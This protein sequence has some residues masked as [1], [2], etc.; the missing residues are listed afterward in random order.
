MDGDRIILKALGVIGR[1]EVRYNGLIHLRGER[2]GLE[3]RYDADRKKWYAYI[4]FESSEKAF[5][6]KWRAISWK[7]RG[8]LVAGIN[9]G[10]NNLMAIYAENSLTRL[11]N[12]RPLKA[13]SHYWNMRITEYQ[14][15]LN[16]YCLKTSKRLR[17][18]Y[19]KWR[20]QVKSYIDAK[21]RQTIEWLYNV[22]ISIIKVGYQRTMRKRMV[23]LTMSKSGHMSTY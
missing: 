16:K 12:G 23:T 13:I 6:G 22:G 11:V 3:I 2:G 20:R 9:I 8:S 10:V 21:V 5:R 18:M 1:I 19:S 4:S 7:P 17:L 14:S 15:T